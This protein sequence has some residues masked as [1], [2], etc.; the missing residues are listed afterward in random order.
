[1]GRQPAGLAVLIGLLLT[2]CSGPARTLE[3]GLEGHAWVGPMCPVVQE[4]V[5]CPDRAL[6]ADLEIL[7]SNGGVTAR[8]RSDE[9]GTFRI[10]LAP[11]DYLLTVARPDEAGLPFASPI[12]FHVPEGVW[13]LLDAHFDSGI[14]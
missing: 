12:P 10:A 11:G 5:D 8:L 3:S 7:D 13:T 1:M 4:G 2:A 9:D 6:E 14:R